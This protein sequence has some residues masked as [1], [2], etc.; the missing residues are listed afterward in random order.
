M[1]GEKPI[2]RII[3]QRSGFIK[4]CLTDATNFC[5]QF[6]LD[7]DVKMKALLM[8]ACFLIVSIKLRISLIHRTSSCNLYVL[9]ASEVHSDLAF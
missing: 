8:G 9:C 4:K 7:M 6:P 1:I 2:G 5:I 3:K